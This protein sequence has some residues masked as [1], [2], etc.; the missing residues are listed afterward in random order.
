[1]KQAYKLNLK[2]RKNIAVLEYI[3][4]DIVMTVIWCYLERKNYK[5]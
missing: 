3:R 5:V 4:L 2:N 1:M